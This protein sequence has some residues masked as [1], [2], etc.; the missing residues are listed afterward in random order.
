[1]DRMMLYHVV[2]VLGT[3]WAIRYFEP[4]RKVVEG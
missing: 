3:V 1:M 2:I 4:V